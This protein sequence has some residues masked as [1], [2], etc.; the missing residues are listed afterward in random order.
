MTRAEVVLGSG[1]D[2]T[3]RRKGRSTGV[4]H[5]PTETDEGTKSNNTLEGNDHVSPFGPS[6]RLKGVCSLLGALGNVAAVNN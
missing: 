3:H 4:L 5:Q 2:L 6:D 1:S